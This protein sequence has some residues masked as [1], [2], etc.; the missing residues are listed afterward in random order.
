MTGEDKNNVLKENSDIAIAKANLQQLIDIINADNQVSISDELGRI[1]SDLKSATNIQQITELLNR[2]N[3]FKN[4]IETLNA[5]IDGIAAK[6]GGSKINDGKNN[7]YDKIDKDIL[8]KEDD[9][10]QKIDYILNHID[11]SDNQEK[12]EKLTKILNNPDHAERYKAIQELINNNPSNIP[13]APLSAQLESLEKS[14]CNK[15]I[16]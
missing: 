14:N 9:F 6:E 1:E 3:E 10:K 11:G 13:E 4:I 15:R 5:V 12:K 16:I 8:T 2:A 7:E